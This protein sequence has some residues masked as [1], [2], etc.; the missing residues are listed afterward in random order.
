MLKRIAGVLVVLA[1]LVAV[2]VAFSQMEQG[3]PPVYTYVSQFNVPRA[4][5]AQ[6][7]ADEEKSFLPI[8]NKML[9]DGSI[10]S[11]TTFET[12]VHTSD[13]YTNG[14]AWSS[15][16]IAGLMKMLEALRSGGPRPGQVA[17]T[18]HED[19]L[20]V[21]TMYGFNPNDKST[22]GYLRV[23]CQNAKPEHPE[24]Y[25]KTLK[26]YLW[27]TFE[28]QLKNGT[29]SYVGL[30]V[31]YVNTSAPST[32]CLVINYPNAQS[33][34]K[35]ATAISAELAKEGVEREILGAVVPDSRR[36]FLA[37][38]THMGHK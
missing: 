18:K 33:M 22:G 30:D 5:W 1:A 34:D 25:G 13:G 11:Y 2:P 26:K 21:T 12:M 36:D 38:I 7:A 6:Y 29:V 15:P 14:A 16:T 19:F 4:N 24:E 17:S 9:A 20:M 8:A 3:Q 10:L 32:R 35:W 31:Q 23:V 37:R 28:E 27:P